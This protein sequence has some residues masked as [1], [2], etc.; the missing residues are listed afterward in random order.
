MKRILLLEDEPVSRDFLTE[1]LT[2]LGWRVEA[3]GDGESAVARAIGQRF[4]ALALDLNLP[5]I[6]GIE[7]LRRIRNRDEHA[8]A[9]APALALSA[10]NRPELHARLRRQ[11]FEAVGCKPL[12]LGEL[13]AV[14]AVLGFDAGQPARATPRPMEGPASLPIWNDAAALTTLG[15]QHDTLTALRQ[16]MLADLP[17][18]CEQILADPDSGATRTVLHRLRAA[19]G[20]C[21]AER[22]ARSVIA[23]EQARPGSDRIALLEAFAHEVATCLATPTGGADE[24]ASPGD[25]LAGT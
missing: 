16:L 5:G 12:T 14:L 10:D 1:A 17:G 7:T 9:D 23:L 15:G 19:C 25:A 4:D 3:F 13:A 8:S 21:G 2:A 18:Q 6:D 11:G 22:L 20:F 24:S